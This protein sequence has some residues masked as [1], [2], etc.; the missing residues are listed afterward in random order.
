[1]KRI[2][3]VFLTVA[4]LVSMTLPIAS[5]AGTP[6]V[7]IS[8]GEAKPGESV[9]LTVSIKD[10]PGLAA[11]KIYFYFDTSVFTTY[12]IRAAGAFGESG[13]LIENSIAI[14]KSNGRYD[15]AVG[16]DG[17]LAFWYNNSGL[18]TT[19]DGEIM[20]IAFR[21]PEKIDAGKYT[22]GIGYSVVDTCDE[23]GDLVALNT[24]DGTITVIGEA[25]TQP[26][27]QSEDPKPSDPPTV[28]EAPRFPD[29]QGH[30]AQAYIEK[31]ADLGLILGNELG[32]YMPDKTMSRAECV[33]I[34]WRA[35]GSPKAT[36]AA[37][38]TDLDPNQKW[39]HEAVAWSAENG[40]IM[41]TGDGTTFSPGDNVNRDQL[42]T[43]L[44][45]MAGEP[46]GKEGMF[47]SVYDARFSDSDQIA[48]WAKRGL[49]WTISEDIYC[50]VNAE[51]V[52]NNTLE[53]GAPALRSQIAVMIVRFLD[54][55]GGK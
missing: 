5:A 12:A 54:K 49:Y 46:T 43:I 31:A 52:E 48:S 3:G 4:L 28:P 21:V 33:T 51:Y 20:K 11:Y 36:K 40:I 7:S 1:M 38:F 24:M 44:H 26:P 32:L 42:A 53:P 17:A 8:S 37:T 47:T 16:K 19:N 22:I 10:N 45:R 9:T 13:G 6:T 15:G 55:Q 27:A 14:A 25:G 23:N 50:G 29:V 30:W 2:L 35:C 18:N 41:G 34:L 39:Y